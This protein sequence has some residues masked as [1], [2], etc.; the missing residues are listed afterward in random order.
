MSSVREYHSTDGRLV[1]IFTPD[2]SVLFRNPRGL[3]FGPGGSIYCV[4]R[5]EAVSFDFATGGLTPEQ[6][7][8]SSVPGAGRAEGHVSRV[9]AKMTLNG[10]GCGL[11]Q[12]E[13]I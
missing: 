13:G 6:S 2:S 8:S 1:R 9:T 12:F 5:E 3:R 11:W 4:A 7:S 10:V